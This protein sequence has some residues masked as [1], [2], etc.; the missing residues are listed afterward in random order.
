MKY[1]ILH[2][3]EEEL[4]K[5]SVPVEE[6]NDELRTL[7]KDMFETMYDAKGVGLA[8][9]QIG[10]NIR[11]AIID[12]GDDPL[13]FINPKITKKSGKETC[14]EGCL[15]FPGL[16]EKVERAVR[17]VVDY[18]DLDGDRYEMEAEGLL[19]RAIQHEL[20]HLDGVVF[21]D[22]ISKARRLQIKWDLEAIKRGE[23]LEDYDEED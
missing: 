13:V 11:L 2:Y 10:K 19:A 12:I 15:S 20:D 14:D 16:S 18:T 23:S 7:V 5:D 17:V 6:I 3:G 21:V 9:P 22:R 4:R 1:R 8:A